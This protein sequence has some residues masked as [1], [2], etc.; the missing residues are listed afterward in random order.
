MLTKINKFINSLVR[1]LVTFGM[2]GAFVVATFTHPDAAE[3][4]AAPSNLLLGW[5]FFERSQRGGTRE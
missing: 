3:V 2:C 1:P 5:W 4:L